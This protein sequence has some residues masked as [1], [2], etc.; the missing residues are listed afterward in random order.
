MS[1]KGNIYLP[2]DP[3]VY[4]RSQSPGFGACWKWLK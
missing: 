2:V 3:N 4:T 1:L